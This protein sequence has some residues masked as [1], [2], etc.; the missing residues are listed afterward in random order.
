MPRFIVHWQERTVIEVQL[1]MLN[2]RCSDFKTIWSTDEK[3]MHWKIKPVLFDACNIKSV[4]REKWVKCLCLAANAWELAA[5]GPSSAPL[6]WVVMVSG[7]SFCWSALG[8]WRSGS[9]GLVSDGLSRTDG[10]GRVRRL[11]AKGSESKAR[12]GNTLLA[13]RPAVRPLLLGKTDSWTA[14]LHHNVLLFTVL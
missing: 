6:V 10:K 13:W 4:A 11:Q 5:L 7:L 9:P 1:V 2:C 12:L 14:S 8:G 3:L